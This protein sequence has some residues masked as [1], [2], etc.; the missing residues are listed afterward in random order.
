MTV[1]PFPVLE[2]AMPRAVA[3]EQAVIGA[4]MVDNRAYER[5]ARIV[6][7]GDFTGSNQVIFAAITVM[8]NEGR[9]IVLLTLAAE[10]SRTAKP[11]QYGG[12]AYLASFLDGAWNVAGVE[13][14][15]RLV[16]IA[17][18][19]RRMIA[20]GY[21]LAQRAS[22]GELPNEL[23]AE[24]VELLSAEHTDDTAAWVTMADL[25]ADIAK[26]YRAGGCEKGL[27]TAWPS[28]DQFY[29][30]ERGAWTLVT[31]I[32]GHGK[33]GWL[34]QLAVNVAR[35][36]DWR[37]AMF[38]AEN[39]PTSRH[40]K[41]IIEKLVSAPF[42]E[43]PTARMR[44]GDVE[45][46]LSFLTKHFAFMDPMREGMTLDRIL[47]LATEEA[48]RRRIDMLT[49]DPWNEIQHNIPEGL[50]ETQYISLQLSKVR[51]WA[52]KHDAHVYV[53]AHPAK[54]QKNR[55]SG[56]YE[57][58]TPYD[59]SGGAHW[60]NKADYSI[61]IYRDMV[62]GDDDPTVSVYVQ[63]ARRREIGHQGRAVL[64]YN[65]ITGEYHDPAE[66]RRIR[67][68]YGADE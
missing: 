9:E 10:L 50:T 48:A 22:E 27:S 24:F 12:A 33:S 54:M 57:P 35:K 46:G 63:K 23:A 28:V 61:T 62:D 37:I 4:V 3:A 16:R 7:A 17:S 36:H 53:V 59:V 20:A 2:Q 18:Q 47:A 30:I 38:S 25:A 49:I 43:G 31:G 60:R 1:L 13:G 6:S 45:R 14:Y 65:K 55:E 42:D 51:R 5:A 39:Y 11:E 41:D 52:R 21:S 26:L 19:Q 56:K 66:P 40:A 64:N 32:P 8:A 34:D 58:P 29:T 15:A 67:E 44:V 68:F